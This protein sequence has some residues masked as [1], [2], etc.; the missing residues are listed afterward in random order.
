MQSVTVKA[1]ARLHLGF[2]DLNASLGRRFG[3]IGLAIESHATKLTLTPSNSFQ[4][5]GELH[6]TTVEKLKKHILHFSEQYGYALPKVNVQVHSL[7]PEHVGFGSGTQLALS[8]ASVLARSLAMPLDTQALAKVMGRGRRSGI[9]IATFDRGGFVIDGGIPIGSTVPPILSQQAFPEEWRVVLVMDNSHQ[10]IHGTQETTAF[11]TLPEFP[12]NHAQ[13]ICHL[14]LMQLLPALHE[15]DIALF[16][17][18]ITAIQALIGDHFAQAQGG[19]YTSQAVAN[20]LEYAHNLGHQ[21][22]AQSSWGPTGC[23]FVESEQAAQQLI[24]Q[25]SAFS[26]D[27]LTFIST[28]ANNKGAEIEIIP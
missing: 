15:K 4:I 13:Q 26:S 9:G 20:C 12:L 1:P 17:S 11:K 22:I 28:Q 21:G 25:L 23:V 5:N 2:L 18:A 27:K 3:S 19:R 10:G 16:G 24:Q 7:I 6:D 14:T 8:I